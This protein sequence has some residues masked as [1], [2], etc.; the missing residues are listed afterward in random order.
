MPTTRCQTASSLEA[1]S[2]VYVQLPHQP[3]AEQRALAE[4]IIST[5]TSFTHD[6][7]GCSPISPNNTRHSRPEPWDITTASGVKAVGLCSYDA[8]VH[9]MSHEVALLGSRLLEGEDAAELVAGIAA[10]PEGALAGSECI[11]SEQS[12]GNVLRVLDSTGVHDVYLRVDGCT[13]LGFD[14]GVTRRGVTV[15]SCGPI[16]AEEPVRMDGWI[17]VLSPCA[18]AG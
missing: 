16:F 15:E 18:P 13:Q 6:S 11:E 10:A 4:E 5:A 1:A 17:D 14:D 9:D 8:L 3:S 2:S 12:P 7:A